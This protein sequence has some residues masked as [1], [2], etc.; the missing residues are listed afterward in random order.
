MATKNQWAERIAYALGNPLDTV[1]KNNI[2]FS[3]DGWRAMFI[4]RD[5]FAN[6]ISDEYL[7]TYFIDL[8]KVDKADNCDFTLDCTILRTRT[9]VP[10]PVRLKS[11]VLFKFVGNADGKPF[12]Y[13]EFEE[14]NYRCSNKYTGKDIFYNY[15]NE[16]I[17]VFNNT[18]LKKL[19]IQAVHVNPEQIIYCSDDPDCYND[20]KNY[21]MPE[22]FFPD[23]MKGIM[24]GDF[25][26]SSTPSEV[27]EVKIDT[28]NG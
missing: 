1:L 28:T 7:Q 13:S 10:K 19:R 24:S 8:I 21:P 11:D 3:L 16:F 17:Y 20:D 18:K 25:R 2:K 4:R 5:V 12:T 6:G 23:I 26:I 22:D 9:R 15:T 14:V 27:E